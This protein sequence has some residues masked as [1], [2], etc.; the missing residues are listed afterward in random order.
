M[1]LFTDIDICLFVNGALYY[2]CY[3]YYHHYYYENCVPID[4]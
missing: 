2:Y 4:K 1:I 3:Y